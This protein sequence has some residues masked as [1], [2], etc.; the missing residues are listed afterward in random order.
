MVITV[1]LGR[2]QAVYSVF[3]L[4]LHGSYIVVTHF[5]PLTLHTKA[6]LLHAV[7]TGGSAV[8]E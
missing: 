2:L 1:S 7:P 5:V 3:N 4:N 6:W 8:P